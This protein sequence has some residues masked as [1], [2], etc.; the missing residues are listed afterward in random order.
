MCQK[1]L[2]SNDLILALQSMVPE[3]LLEVFI[4]VNQN[5]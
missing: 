4:S 5:L 1:S 3:V 2:D